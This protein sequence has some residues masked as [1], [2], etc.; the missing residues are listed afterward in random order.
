MKQFIKWWA[1]IS[2]ATFVAL[3]LAGF[4]P[5]KAGEWE[6]ML[7][8]ALM[9]RD[10]KADTAAV[11]VTS[12]VPEPVRLEMPTHMVIP[13]VKID[14]A[15][16]EPEAVTNSALDDALAKGIVHYP[17]S[18][19]LGESANMLLF[20]HSS[21]LAHVRNQAYKALTGID[22]VIPGESIMI[23][24]QEHEYFYEVTS[25]HRADKFEELVEFKTGER[26]LTI[27]TCDTF[28]K[29]D[30]RYVIKAKFKERRP[31]QPEQTEAVSE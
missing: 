20:G 2:F 9:Y 7:I 8:S 22:K 18:G 6:N 16:V 3:S 27:S 29:K 15:I 25:V 14:F 30:D 26:E 4:I 1:G 11:P 19:L 23:R 12:P 28:G 5:K 21:H 13:S 10:A 24:G 17:G 31:I